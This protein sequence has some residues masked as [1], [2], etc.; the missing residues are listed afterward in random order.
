MGV[1]GLSR[2][3]SELTSWGTSS[4]SE[5]TT[6]SASQQEAGAVVAPAC[7]NPMPSHHLLRS[8][9]NLKEGLTPWPN[10]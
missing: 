2:H 10:S 5:Q 4:G 3:P 7:G 8:S 1:S 6:Q 9:K